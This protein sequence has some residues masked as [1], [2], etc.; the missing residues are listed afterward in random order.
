MQLARGLHQCMHRRV[1][2]C[3]PI[4]IHAA[5]AAHLK[6]CA[7]CRFSAVA[8]SFRRARARDPG[9]QGA[10]VRNVRA[11]G[12]CD[13]SVSSVLLL[14]ARTQSAAPLISALRRPNALCPM[15][16]ACPQIQA[17]HRVETK[18]KERQIEKGWASGPDRFKSSIVARGLLTRRAP[19]AGQ[20]T[21]LAARRRATSMT[22]GLGS[23]RQMNGS[24]TRPPGRRRHRACSTPPSLR[25]RKCSSL[26]DTW[27][28]SPRRTTCTRL[29]CSTL[30]ARASSGR[31][32]KCQE[33]GRPSVTATQRLWSVHG[34]C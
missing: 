25:A 34:W 22:F 2:R 1:M 13:G 32:R 4:T 16:L 24:A 20:S 26:E 3:C 23:A 8:V 28:M 14:A 12:L 17:D 27:K 11:D 30:S 9:E 31:S 33:K 6:L 15:P 18:G 21:S 10:L 19:W 7:L 29:T 5:N